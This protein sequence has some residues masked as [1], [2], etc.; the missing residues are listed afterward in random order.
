MEKAL[1]ETIK[2]LFNK[3][4]LKKKKVTNSLIMVNW[5]TQKLTNKYARTLFI[6]I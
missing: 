2:E 5:K 4:K 1:I 6:S 3:G